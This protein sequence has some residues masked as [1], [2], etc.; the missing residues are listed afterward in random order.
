MTKGK[1]LAILIAAS[2]LAGGQAAAPREQTTVID[3]REA[4]VAGINPAAVEIWDVMNAARAEG[5]ELD[6]GVMDDDRWA[7]LR[8]SAQ[9]LETWSRMM[10]TA[11]SIR[12][13]G[14]NLVEDRVPR[15]A[16]SR[17]EIQ[18]MIDRDPQGFRAE[19]NDLAERAARLVAAARARDASAAG[20]RAVEIAAPCQGCHTRY[21]FKRGAAE[22]SE[23]RPRA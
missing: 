22:L 4:M 17:E 19:A 20:H 11:D 12:A 3:T 10:A 13:A 5:G 23:S 7:R 16:A 15:G 6:R 21:W 18:A 14:P 9:M 8:E 2:T 1:P